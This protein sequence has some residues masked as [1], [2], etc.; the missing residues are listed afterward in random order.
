MLNLVLFFIFL[1]QRELNILAVERWPNHSGHPLGFLIT[2]FK[3][4]DKNLQNK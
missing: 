2:V 3:G 4:T 1:P